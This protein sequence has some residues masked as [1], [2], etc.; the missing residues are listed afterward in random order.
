MNSDYTSYCKI[1]SLCV[2]SVDVRMWKEKELM[3]NL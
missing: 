3:E 1:S 2:N